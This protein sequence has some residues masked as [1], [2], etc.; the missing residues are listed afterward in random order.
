MQARTSALESLEF[1]SDDFKKI[2][3]SASD[4]V[5]QAKEPVR[6]ISH[7]DA[8]G[9]SAAGII[10]LALSRANKRFQTSM[11]TS[12]DE[13]RAGAIKEEE[14][15]LTIFMDMGSGQLDLLKELSGDIIILDHHTPQT[16]GN[17]K[18]T[19]IE[20]NCHRFGIDGTS[21]ACASTMAFLL[22]L[23]MNETN[24]DLVDL[25]LSGA[26]GDKQHLEGLKGI[27]AKIEVEAEARGLIKSSRNLALFGKTLVEGITNSINP[28]F[29]GLTGDADAVKK[30]MQSLRI[31]PEHSPMELDRNVVE[32]LGSVLILKLLRQGV[33]QEIA[34][35]LLLTRYISV[36]RKMDIENFSH[37]VNS[38]GRMHKQSV[39]LAVCFGDRKALVEA[40]EIRADYKR[41]IRDNMI[42]ISRQELGKKK[43]I[44]FLYVEN[45]TFAGTY[46]GLGM[47]FLFDQER[48]VIVLTKEE[49]ETKISGRG[50]LYLVDKGLDLAK[51]LHD[52]AVPLSG[53]GGGHP[54]AAGATI[55]AGKEDKFLNAVNKIVGDQLKIK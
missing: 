5:M 31:D 38:C 3:G 10:S 51:A 41:Q 42:E 53:V 35:T 21:E 17:K 8:D 23:S 55:P 34:E 15:E 50:T 43:A 49:K 6:V 39:G 4:R 37:I 13:S 27:N 46:A 20:I 30:F 24:W 40:E 26:T 28:F 54:V 48:P 7:Y 18:R 19:I 22:A 14:N 33:R 9:I 44:Q 25:A 36:K 52:A 16:K 12:L 1:L 2:F 47:Q 29:K 45:Q 11:I 32:K